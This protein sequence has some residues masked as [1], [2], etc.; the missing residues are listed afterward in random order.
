MYVELVICIVSIVNKQVY[1]V[2]PY[3]NIT[4]NIKVKLKQPHYRPGVAQRVPGS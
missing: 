2:V 1:T 4:I 3:C